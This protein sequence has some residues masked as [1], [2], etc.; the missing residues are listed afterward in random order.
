A[1][2]SRGRSWSFTNPS[3][4]ATSITPGHPDFGQPPEDRSHNGSDAH[5]DSGSPKGPQS[6]PDGNR[7]TPARERHKPGPGDC[8]T[9]GHEQ[10]PGPRPFLRTL[11]EDDS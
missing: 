5:P 10:H 6:I 4:H 9:D 1:N 11:A 8:R 7:V 2:R 3:S